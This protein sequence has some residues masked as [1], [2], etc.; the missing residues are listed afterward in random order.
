MRNSSAKILIFSILFVAI[1][2]IVASSLFV[3]V[4]NDNSQVFTNSED[5]IISETAS[6]SNVSYGYL[7]NGDGLQ[8]GDVPAGYTTD[9]SNASPIS[10]ASE[11]YT[12]LRAKG[13]YTG[14]Y[15]L[16]AD[17]TNWDYVIT[18]DSDYETLE[19]KALQLI[20]ELK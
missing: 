3:F 5:V 18:N 8:D 15:Y 2:A 7:S 11:L 17:I 10:S 20:E 12:I 16:T 19:K 4:L 1:F 13:T 9:L 6:S 14:N